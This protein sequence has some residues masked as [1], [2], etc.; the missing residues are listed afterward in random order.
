MQSSKLDFITIKKNI[1]EHY[2]N[3]NIENWLFFFFFEVEV[4]HLQIK[5]TM[6]ILSAAESLP[7]ERVTKPA[8]IG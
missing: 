5:L 1:L 3:L 2:I 6:I 4:T 8:I 7:S